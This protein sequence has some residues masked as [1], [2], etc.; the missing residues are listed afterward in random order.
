MKNEKFLEG[1]RILDDYMPADGH[2]ITAEHDQIWIWA[3]VLSEAHQ[4]ELKELGWFQDPGMGSHGW[5]AF[6]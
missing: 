3:H 5:S 6:V 4:K 2:D 1:I